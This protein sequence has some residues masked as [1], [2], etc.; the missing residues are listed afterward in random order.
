MSGFG[1]SASCVLEALKIAN[2]VRKALKDAGGA[3]AQYQDAVLYFNSFH[4]TFEHLEDH[5]KQTTDTT[6]SDTIQSQ[7]KLINAP[8]EKFKTSFGKY[9]NSLSKASTRSR[10]RN[11]PRKVQWALKELD[12]EIQNLKTAISQPLQA[13][14]CILHL[15]TL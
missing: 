2:K 9:E 8:W 12:I 15:K 1:W 4:A 3:A 13:I 5:I 14:K 7:L 6:Y 10:L 11:T